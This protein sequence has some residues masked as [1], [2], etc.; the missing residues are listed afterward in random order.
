[1]PTTNNMTMLSPWMQTLRGNAFDFDDLDSNIFDAEEVATVL[2][3]LHRFGGHTRWPYTVAQHSVLV[4]RRAR[5]DYMLANPLAALLHDVAESFIGDMIA[6]LKGYL[7]SY[8]DNSYATLENRILS[9]VARVHDF[10][11]IDFHSDRIRFLDL[12]AL[13]TEA[14]DVMIS[15]PPREWIKLPTPW[16][17]RIEPWESSYA[18]DAWLGLYRELV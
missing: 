18:R 13:A 1:M 2:S 9:W 15:P 8:G 3:R 5:T 6:P 16:L 14:R 17:Q 12:Q 11:S 4:S 7:K 10:P